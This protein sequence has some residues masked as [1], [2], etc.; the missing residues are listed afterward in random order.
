MTEAVEIVEIF[1]GQNPKTQPITFTLTRANVPYIRFQHAVESMD[2][3]FDLLVDL[4]LF[5]VALGSYR[6]LEVTRPREDEYHPHLHCLIV[7]PSA[8]F[9]QRSMLYVHPRELS[10]LWGR[11]LG[12]EYLPVTNMRAVRNIESL[13]KWFHYLQKPATDYAR[14]I[15]TSKFGGRLAELEQRM[16]SREDAAYGTQRRYPRHADQLARQ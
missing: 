1:L 12:V 11:A 10:K 4:A 9:S 5:K 14:V 2:T 7:V 15:E 3:A 16:L 8:Y 13:R 6:H